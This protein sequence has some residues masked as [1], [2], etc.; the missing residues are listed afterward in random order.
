[1]ADCIIP[2]M[3]YGRAAASLYLSQQVEEQHT[4]PAH[5]A[6]CVL[7]GFG[8]SRAVVSVVLLP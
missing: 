7:I 8:L 3:M 6:M 5:S 4:K 2:T 1:M